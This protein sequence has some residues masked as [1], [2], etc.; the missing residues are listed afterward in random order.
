[1]SLK[2]FLGSKIPSWV[3]YRN[4]TMPFKT[5]H[6]LPSLVDDEET[7]DHRWKKSLNEIEKVE[8]RNRQ[9]L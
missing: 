9:Y 2:M 5:P 8:T 6:F 1:M 4:E 7:V 3:L